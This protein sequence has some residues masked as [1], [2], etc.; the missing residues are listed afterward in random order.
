LPIDSQSDVKDGDTVSVDKEP[1]AAALSFSVRRQNEEQRRGRQNR[2]K[3]LG[4][5]AG[6]KDA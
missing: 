1:K 2:G 3:G 6:V 4:R 5:P